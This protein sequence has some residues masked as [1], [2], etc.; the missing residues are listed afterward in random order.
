MKYVAL[1]WGVMIIG[2]LLGYK[3]RT[4]QI[5]KRLAEI[6][7]MSSVSILV[8]IMGLRMGSNQAVIDNVG[9]IGLVALIITFALWAGAVIAVTIARKIMGIDK[10]GFFNGDNT[11]EEDC[12]LDDLED[13]TSWE[14]ETRG[15]KDILTILIVISVLTGLAIGFF[16]IRKVFT[17]AQIGGFSNVTSTLLV[18]GLCIMI[19]FIGYSMGLSGTIINEL[20]KIGARV[21]VIPVAVILGTTVVAMVLGMVL[22]SLT[23]RESLAISYGYGWYT[24]APIAISNAGHEI[25]GAIS[26]MHNV[27]REL[28]GI[29]LIPILA[30]KIGYIESTT[31]PGIAAMDV[32]LPIITKATREEIIAYAFAIG[33][34]EELATTIMVPLMIGA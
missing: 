17:T 23:V 25:A 1:Y 12:A 4:A 10:W 22:P 28:G 9:S 14:E 2:Y 32:C 16:F 31:L 29:V 18:I 11:P 19:S 6:I 30:S 7:I 13:K 8:L 20:R 27:I 15:S 3:N 5:G 33:L 24:Y 26:F 34:V 21:F